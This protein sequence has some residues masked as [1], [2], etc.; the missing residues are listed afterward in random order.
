[1]LVF[2][3]GPIL[4]NIFTTFDLT[5]LT[6]RNYFYEKNVEKTKFTVGPP[7]VQVPRLALPSFRHCISPLTWWIPWSFKTREKSS[8][9]SVRSVAAGFFAT[10]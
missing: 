9:A 8:I 3:P 10:L 4:P 5:L 2:Y 6:R 1:M 7:N